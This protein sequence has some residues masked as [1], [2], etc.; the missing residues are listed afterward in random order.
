M[1]IIQRVNVATFLSLYV[2]IPTAVDLTLFRL[3]LHNCY[4][5]NEGSSSKD[6]QYVHVVFHIYFHSQNIRETHI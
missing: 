5:Y 6:S 2:K 4:K 3:S 1:Y